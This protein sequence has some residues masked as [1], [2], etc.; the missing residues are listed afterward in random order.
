MG[1]ADGTWE[2]VDMKD[3]LLSHSPNLRMSVFICNQ[4][5]PFHILNEELKSGGGDQGMSGGCIWKPFQITEDE[6]VLI[7]DNMLTDPTIKLNYDDIL[8]EKQTLKQWC[9][10]VLSKYNPRNN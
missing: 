3:F 5:P 8:E 10:G 7:R 2:I 4:F 6:Y 9:G 1:A